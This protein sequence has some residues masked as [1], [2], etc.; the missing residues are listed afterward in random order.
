MERVRRTLALSLLAAAAAAIAAPSAQAAPAGPPYVAALGDSYVSGEGGRWAG[1]TSRGE[2]Y[3]DAGGP[4]AY[5]DTTAGPVIPGCDRSLSE[6]AYIGG[7]VRGVDFACSGA[8]T[9]SRV[10][11][12]GRF[13]PGVDLYRDGEGHVGQALMLER[14]ARSHRVRLVILSIGG[15]DFGFGAI[16]ARCVADYVS[17]SPDDPNLCRDDRTVQDRFAPS[18][19]AAVRRRIARSIRDVDRAMRQAG[20]ARSR[21]TLL[22]QD[23]PSPIPNGSGFR[24]PQT[25]HVRQSTGG[26]GF[27]DADAAWANRVALPAM[28]NALFEAG[29]RTGLS[30][31]ERLRIRL[32]FRGRRLC[33]WT[34]GRLEEAGVG[35]WDDPGAV[36]RI[37]WFQGIRTVTA[38]GSPYSLRESVHP[39]YYAQLALRNCIR[40][41][42][43]G[44]DPRGGA[45]A[46]AGPGL[47]RRGEPRMRLR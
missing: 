14:W 33:E 9:A 21:W 28:D 36:D 38:A 32:A 31:I 47:N 27:W 34:V 46:I 17:S 10:A 40:R 12:G 3:V 5:A 22:L 20:Y 44:G 45:C 4:D 41:A 24:Y 26:C 43:R 11:S 37:E 30:N 6:E 2:R 35:F 7:G 23:Y 8:R 18:R 1:N 19:V 42:Y 29:E 39:D 25:R 16:V 13:V 15:N